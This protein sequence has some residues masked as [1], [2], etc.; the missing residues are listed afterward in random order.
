MQPASNTLIECNPQ[1]CSKA[2][3]A[4][5]LAADT[6]SCSQAGAGG[7]VVKTHGT[8]EVGAAVAAGG[9]RF[10]RGLARQLARFPSH[11]AVSA[12]TALGNLARRSAGLQAL[13]AAGPHLVTEV[14]HDLADMADA[15]QE[16]PRAEALT[17]LCN[18]LQHDSALRLLVASR[19]AMDDIVC[20]V[21]ACLAPYRLR[22]ALDFGGLDMEAVS[23][24]AA[25]I[26]RLL[27]HSQGQAAVAHHAEVADVAAG[28]ASLVVRS[29]ESEAALSALQALRVLLDGAL[30]RPK[31]VGH[32]AAGPLL[33]R[34]ADWL[35]LGFDSN[36]PCLLSPSRADV[37]G[38][39]RTEAGEYV[40]V[41]TVILR[42][43]DG[44]GR[45]EHA[46]PWRDG[47][48]HARL[49]AVTQLVRDGASRLEQARMRLQQERQAAL[50]S[51]GKFKG[52]ERESDRQQ[53]LL[54]VAAKAAETLARFAM[55]EA[56]ALAVC[57][58]V[59]VV[60]MVKDL[61]LLGSAS[62]PAWRAC[63]LALHMLLSHESVCRDLAQHALPHGDGGA[64]G[65][66]D[67]IDLVVTR[68]VEHLSPSGRRS[69]DGTELLEGAED[70][71]QVNVEDC[72][73]AIA[74]L[75]RCEDVVKH[76]NRHPG[77]HVLLL[78]LII[79]CAE[80]MRSDFYVDSATPG[81]AD[82]CDA[83]TAILGLLEH[84]P[85]ARVALARTLI[86]L[87]HAML[88]SN[89]PSS[90]PSGE[91]GRDEDEVHTE[92]WRFGGEALE[93][94][95][96]EELEVVLTIA[97][98][99]VLVTSEPKMRQLK[100][101]LLLAN[102]LLQLPDICR[103]VPDSIVVDHAPAV[104]AKDSSGLPVAHAVLC[105]LLDQ[106][107]DETVAHASFLCWALLACEEGG[108][109]P[110]L[111]HLLEN[112]H[113][114][115][116][117]T[118][119]ST[120]GSLVRDSGAMTGKVATGTTW[121]VASDTQIRAASKGKEEGTTETSSLLSC[122]MIKCV[123]MVDAS[124]TVARRERAGVALLDRLCLSHPARLELSRLRGCGGQAVDA[125]LSRLAITPHIVHRLLLSY[126]SKLPVAPT[127]PPATHAPQPGND[128][129]PDRQDEQNVFAGRRCRL[130]LVASDDSILEASLASVG[131]LHPYH[132]LRGGGVTLELRD[133]VGPP[134]G[135]EHG[136]G[137]INCRSGPG[138]GVPF[139]VAEDD[140]E[141]LGRWFHLV[142]QALPRR[143]PVAGHEDAVGAA[144][145][146]HLL[147]L[148]GCS[149]FFG[150][151]LA[152]SVLFH[153]CDGSLLAPSCWPALWPAL[154][155]AACR[156]AQAAPSLPLH[157]QVAAP[158]APLDADQHRDVAEEVWTGIADLLPA[159]LLAL[160]TVPELRDTFLVAGFKSSLVSLLHALD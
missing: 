83:A 120:P 14:V 17:A 2:L 143:V 121:T 21:A 155:A 88:Q 4:L 26:A 100:A 116:D 13:L 132:L 104:R 52:L 62:S 157:V 70:M 117:S 98:T 127:P 148:P 33:S 49:Q 24:A 97:H 160:L 58:Q 84:S 36:S 69:S 82:R 105:M 118:G 79:L 19:A 80:P 149:R 61:M 86:Y 68:L 11:A 56:G 66:G 106:E 46:A 9:G 28:L 45:G 131:A 1:L 145:G 74:G 95:L 7:L 41:E 122:V 71:D 27:S 144:G 15:P 50:A 34:L 48:A 43:L 139:M 137:E 31:F 35:L 76:L 151:L 5:L 81:P 115:Q 78:R 138:K 12:A 114:C 75:A 60:K 42:V 29:R 102:L 22:Q 59:D 63:Q 150:R 124:K 99:P 112:A 91:D 16:E 119:L 3:T 135:P 94:A 103:F 37:D 92:A 101:S 87:T 152:M 32:V 30:H 156:D 134:G 146:A 153:S 6:C 136:E 67:L 111:R 38:D 57:S 140:G 123:K 85:P 93:L 18:L 141:V 40:V 133:A 96:R 126:R 25:L 47:D 128:A 77:V 109:A 129:T 107:C 51:G 73:G 159:H 130:T 110:K 53:A 65:E 54:R 125:A 8:G 90:S 72:A 89:P 147:V 108:V 154:H 39:S 142:A 10:L 44:L 20:G 64:G 23:D 55:H 158:A 113:L